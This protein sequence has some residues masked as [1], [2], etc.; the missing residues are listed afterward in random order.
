SAQYLGF[1][2]TFFAHRVGPHRCTPDTDAMHV[3]STDHTRGSFSDRI[4]AASGA[5]APL[6]APTQRKPFSTRASR[7]TT[8]GDFMSELHDLPGIACPADRERF[9]RYA[10]AHSFYI[11]EQWLGKRRRGETRLIVNY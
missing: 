7:L 4:V 1:F 6:C 11:G 10:E 5:G 8:K 9:A 3:A 2:A